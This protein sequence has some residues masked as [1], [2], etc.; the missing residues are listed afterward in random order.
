M[1]KKKAEKIL[2]YKDLTI[3]IRCTWNVK[4]KS[5]N[6]SNK[7]ITKSYR[8]YLSNRLGKHKTN[9]LQEKALL[10]TSDSTNVNVQYVFKIQNNVTRSTNCKYRTAGTLHT[11]ETR[12]VSDI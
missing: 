11:R 7:D 9:K 6:S 5:D 10:C 1:I 2:K 8:Q 4:A 12:F 3:E